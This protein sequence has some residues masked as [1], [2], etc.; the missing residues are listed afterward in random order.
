MQLAFCATDV[1]T[2]PLASSSSH[3][4]RDNPDPSI[5]IATM[6]KNACKAVDAA[7]A[8]VEKRAEAVP[9]DWFTPGGYMRLPHIQVSEADR[10]LLFGKMSPTFCDHAHVD[11][12]FAK[13]A[14]KLRGDAEKLARIPAL[15]AEVK[16]KIDTF[17]AEREPV[18]VS[19]GL[20]KASDDFY[21]A[22]I[23]RTN[24]A[25]A[26]VAAIPTTARG[27]QALLSVVSLA[28]TSEDRGESIL[29]PK[30]VSKITRNVSTYL[31]GGSR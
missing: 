17:N 19:S 31:G 6:F 10:A 22:R 26:L 8:E 30:E 27:A 9:A 13:A 5:A 11:R 2:I 20:Q 3:R 28:V 4:L 16:N 25:I 24:A 29:R 14:K 23:S 1:R 7:Q 18:I 21:A 15:I 12:C